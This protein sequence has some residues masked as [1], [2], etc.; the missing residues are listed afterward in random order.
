MVHRKSETASHLEYRGEGNFFASSEIC[1]NR[2]SDSEGDKHED[3]HDDKH[4]VMDGDMELELE[5]DVT[6]SGEC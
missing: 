1:G 2:C 6:S 4:E 3:K 5:S